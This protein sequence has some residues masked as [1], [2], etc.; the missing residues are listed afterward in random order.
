MS[1]VNRRAMGVVAAA[2]S[3]TLVACNSPAVPSGSAPAGKASLT[4]ALSS[5]PSATALKELA[6]AFE[7][8]SGITM[9]VVE[10]TYDQIATKVLL[11]AGQ[12]KATYDIVQFD[13]PMY[14]ALASGN[15]LAD[16]GGYLEA[17]A[18]YD[19]SDFPDQVKEYARFGDKSLAIPL[20]T[21]PYILW[22]N[23]AL[24]KENNLSIADTLSDYAANAKALGEAGA[25][26]SN[27][28]FGP[29]IGAYYWLQSVYLHGG[30]LTQP[31]TCTSALDSPEA[32]AATDFYFSMLPFTPA[33]SVNGG[34]NEMTTAFVQGDVGQMV[35]AT[36]YYSIVSDPEQSKIPESFEMS[37]PPRN[38][39][40]R[41]TLMFGWLIGVTAN[42]SAKDE[43]WSF[44]EFALG[45]DSM[46]KLIDLG[47]PP[48]ARTSL[49]TS[50]TAKKAIPYVELLVNAS[51]F[52]EH[53][54]YTPVMSE[55]ITEV[56]AQLSEAA[57][58]G[59]GPDAFLTKAQES[60]S[61]ILA[62]ADVCK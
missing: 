51:S 55:I 5:S 3:V 58:D 61:R 32:K 8:S 25:Y 52:G 33:T 4:I 11:A 28:G 19:Y 53:L 17:S 46:D 36:G 30:R 31:G 35:N 1:T 27:S 23:T 48:P 13:S 41:H 16:L 50:A 2:L 21:E 22:N 40:G 54:P 45:K 59:S 9:N 60:V 18:A 34:G 7:A 37:L 56:S 20:S 39:T 12:E 43:A 49:T 26:G 15:A 47:A 24:L 42:S 38:D 57:S 29:K 6:K 44:L 62:D 14:A 10:L